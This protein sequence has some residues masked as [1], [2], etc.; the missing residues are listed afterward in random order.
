MSRPIE[1]KELIANIFDFAKAGLGVIG[2][3]IQALTVA[4]VL[5]PPIALCL[6]AVSLLCEN[7]ARREESGEKLSRVEQG[8]QILI[9]FLLV[10]SAVLGIVSAFVAT[11]S[12]LAPFV[13]VGAAALLLLSTTYQLFLKY[14]DPEFTQIKADRSALLDEIKQARGEKM[15]QH[16]K[17][18]IE[19]RADPEIAQMLPGLSDQ[20]LSKLSE[21]LAK[22]QSYSSHIK[23]VRKLSFKSLFYASFLT[24]SVIAA[25]AAV[26]NPVTGPAILAGVIGAYMMYSVGVFSKIKKFFRRAGDDKVYSH[27]VSKHGY[28]HD[29]ALKLVVNYSSMH[30]QQ[31]EVYHALM[32]SGHH[33]D[34][35]P[36]ALMEKAKNM[37][38][39]KLI[40]PK[41]DIKKLEVVS[42]L[43]KDQRMVYDKYAA[44]GGHDRAHT[45]AQFTRHQLAVFE[46]EV[47]VNKV[48]ID[49]AISRVRSSHKP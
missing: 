9:S 4:S 49:D 2:H 3:A 20:T 45:L 5:L 39:V 23:K 15:M 8:A 36:D 6:E 1:K 38:D 18:L 21:H 43:S 29:E 31:Q 25:V 48:K 22:E 13:Y 16:V 44:K 19:S 41:L 34:I 26:A 27:A 11:L 42:E 7:T 12:P 32:E 37:G 24:M 14:K 46:K 28:Q 17:M 30:E 35:K 10:G 40:H 33:L 47:K